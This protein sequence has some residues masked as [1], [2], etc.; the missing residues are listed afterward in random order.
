M[1]GDGAVLAASDEGVYPWV[2]DTPESRRPPQFL[3]RRET[4]EER[5]ARVAQEAGLIAAARARL[6]AGE[7][8]SGDGLL[9]WLGAYERSDEA[10][11]VP[12]TPH[13]TRIRR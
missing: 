1:G 11:P 13:D 7:G 10:V 5:R 9:A 3:R 8:V 2:M 12:T 4:D 6:D